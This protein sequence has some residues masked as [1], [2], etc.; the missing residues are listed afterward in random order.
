MNIYPFIIQRDQAAKNSLIPDLYHHLGIA[1]CLQSDLA[2]ML[3]QNI[4]IVRIWCTSRSGCTK[5]R[6]IPLHTT[7]KNSITQM[8]HTAK[9]QTNITI[10]YNIG[11]LRVWRTSGS[12]CSKYSPISDLLHHGGTI[13]DCPKT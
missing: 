6:L 3:R 8:S 13:L 7:A 1:Q 2:R 4:I 12:G 9:K 10:G 5:C 11:I